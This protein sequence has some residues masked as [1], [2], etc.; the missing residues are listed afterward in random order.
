M[1]KLLILAI[2]ILTLSFLVF[3]VIDLYH[4]KALN[5]LENEKENHNTKKFEDELGIKISNGNTIII[6]FNSECHYCENEINE[7]RNNIKFFENYQLIFLSFEPKSNAI[8][9]LNNYNLSQMYYEVNPEFLTSTIPGGVPQTF[10]YKDGELEKHFKG[11][12]KIEAI[13]EILK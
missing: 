7:V 6:Y 9:F 4:Q 10:I 1:K 2:L 8:K 13:L 5:N 12:A 11:E 3:K